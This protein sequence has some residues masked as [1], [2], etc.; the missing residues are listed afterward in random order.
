M[1]VLLINKF[2]HL[3]GG[4][5]RHVFEWEKLLRA[6]GHEAMVFSMKDPRNLP[7]AQ[8]R[9]FIEPVRFDGAQGAM[10]KLRAAAHSIWS[11]E[12]AR[13]M[14][15]LLSAERAPDIAHVHSFVYQLTPSVLGPLARRGVPIVQTCH[16]YAHICANQH[17]YNQRTEKPCEEC[18]R[19]GR[20]APL[21]TRCMKGSFA[22]SAAG[23]AA[24]LVDSV[25]GRSRTR[26]R[27]FFAVSEYTR[28]QL[29]RGGLPAER[30]FTTPN[31]IEPES[32]RP[33]EG[34]GEYLLFLGR[35]TPY[36][37]I[38]TFLRAARLA[39]GVPC[40]VAGT[41]ALEAETRRE[42]SGN[43]EVLGHREGEEL[44]EIVRRARAVVVPSEWYEPF[45]LVI[46]EA[47]AA[48]RAVIA[49]RLAGPA[50]IVADG[51]DGLL[52]PAGDAEALAAAMSR[53]WSTPELATELGRNGRAKIE[54]EYT[55][56]AHYG[57]MMKH[58][59][60]VLRAKESAE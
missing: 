57:R 4:A 51:R 48:R 35:L 53:L 2:Y 40:K 34:A 22:A 52:T 21:W 8:E 45:G 49:S 12:A 10:A 28:A 7:C 3:N 9:Y 14:E 60:Q 20:L 6:H 54:R 42:A 37:G 25:F 38:R 32:I 47:M 33:G 26:I 43:V 46:L 55:A 30:V 18:L 41:G 50:E 11:R 44:W 24:G 15:A 29:I 1:K 5:E 23:V 59:E 31:F 58:F 13:R 39:T 17:L 16:E 36:K 19:R 27:R 56:E